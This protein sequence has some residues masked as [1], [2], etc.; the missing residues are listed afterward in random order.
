[1]RPR[2]NPGSP[3]VL[4][5]PGP[6]PGPLDGVR[7]IGEWGGLARWTSLGDG[8]LGRSGDPGVGTEARRAI[9]DRAWVG[10]RQ[11][12][13]ADVAVVLDAPPSLPGELWDAGDA[14]ALVTNR[15]DIAISVL[16]ADCA[17]VAFGSPEGIIGAAHGGW[18]G[19]AAGVI[20]RTVEAM[21]ALGASRVVA[22][23]GPCAHG[24]CYEFSGDELSH[25][26]RQFGPEVRSTTAAGRPALDL[27]AA[28]FSA[29]RTA[30]AQLVE[31]V[32]RCTICDQEYFSFRRDHT[33]GRQALVVWQS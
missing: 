20:G 8:D 19:V 11:V 4:E 24:E 13:G 14:D 26:E 7:P 2:A 9:L 30:G 10:V 33:T 12:H 23:L 18:R 6:N 21:V 25:L 15:D 17:T 16:S 22:A 31:G 29:L 5:D 32:D 28:V 1:M 3:N 27:P